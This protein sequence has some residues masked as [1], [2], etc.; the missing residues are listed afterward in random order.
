MR[1][2]RVVVN[3][4]EF[5]V[6]IEEI[7][8]AGAAADVAAVAAPREVGTSPA[9]PAARPVSRPAAAS[10]TGAIIAQ[11]PGTIVGVEVSSGDRVTR[12][13][14]L[15]ILE[16]MKM[17]NEVVAPADGVVAEVKVVKGA[18]VNAGDV[19]VVLT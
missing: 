6:A 15:L 12:G 11:M 10:P 8:G 13:Q 2:F 7:A 9:S 3:G 19:L 1:R 5:E 18:S 16:A 17:A 14:T 4:S